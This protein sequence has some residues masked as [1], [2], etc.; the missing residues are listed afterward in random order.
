MSAFFPITEIVDRYSIAKLK[1]NK[2]KNNFDELQF[3]Q[4]QM[5]LYDILCI[6]DELEQLYE[7]HSNIWELESQLKRGVEHQLSL[8]EIGRRAIKI[9]DWNNKRVFLKNSMAIKLGQGN[10]TEIKKD[11]LSE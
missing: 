11:H 3:Y 9:R 6:K 2:T 5:N 8:D 7:I 4:T 10:I 1:F